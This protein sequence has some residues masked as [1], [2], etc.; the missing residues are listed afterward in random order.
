MRCATNTHTMTKNHWWWCN[1][2]HTIKKAFWTNS[3][4]SSKWKN[5]PPNFVIVIVG[6]LGATP[7]T[8]HGPT[9]GGPFPGGVVQ[10]WGTELHK[11]DLFVGSLPLLPKCLVWH[12]N[13]LR[14]MHLWTRHCYIDNWVWCKRTQ[15]ILPAS[16][17]IEQRHPWVKV[18]VIVCKISRLNLFD[19]Y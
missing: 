19:C 6:S 11:P 3:N 1:I 14:V 8:H 9:F 18:N 4:D 13:S 16:R 2:R 7:Q 10:S 5:W 15:T 17:D 12:Q